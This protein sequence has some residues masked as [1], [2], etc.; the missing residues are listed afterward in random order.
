M[1]TNRAYKTLSGTAAKALPYFI[2]KVKDIPFGDPSRYQTTFPFTYS[3][4]KRLGF[5]KSTFHKVLGQLIAHGFI[6]LEKK[7]G[8]RSFGM[9]NSIFKLSRRWERFGLSVFKDGNW[10]RCYSAKPR[11][12]PK[13]NPTSPGSEPVKAS[14]EGV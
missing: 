9:S 6:D 2:G 3:E 10:Q 13:V 11:L 12:A 5:G 4:A 1:L 8:K 7:G 14:A